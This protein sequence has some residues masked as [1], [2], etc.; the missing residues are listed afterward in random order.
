LI[1]IGLDEV[2]EEE[3]FRKNFLL[4]FTE[5]NFFGCWAERLAELP[6]PGVIAVITVGRVV[7]P[8]CVGETEV[9]MTTFS[10]ASMVI[11]GAFSRT[12]VVDFASKQ[13]SSNPAD[14]VSSRLDDSD[15]PG[16]SVS[17]FAINAS[18][19]AIQFS[20]SCD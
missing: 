19:D 10:S 14:P 17:I 15:S 1:E 6:D 11:S 3:F 18:Q 4:M 5:L 9:P 20:V 16:V 12:A 2:G 8:G 7:D 13:T